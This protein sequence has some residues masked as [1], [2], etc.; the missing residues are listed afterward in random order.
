MPKLSPIGISASLIHVCY[1]MKKTCLILFCSALVLACAPDA[2]A[3]DGARFGLG[4]G[5][6]SSGLGSLDLDGIESVFGPASLYVP[7]T[8]SG[9]RLEPEFGFFRTSMDEGDFESSVTLLQIGTGIFALSP[10]GGAIIYYGG[11][12]GLIR[13]SSSF[14][15]PSGE[16]DDSSNNF[17]LGPA[18]GGEY[19]F[20]DNFSL[21]GEMQLIYTSFD[22]DE[23][24][25]SIIRTRG[26]FFIRWH[27]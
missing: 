2:R 23:G 18:T 27:F 1:A 6:S 5:L 10:V 25:F 16:G 21:G 19:Y 7:I 26:V 13:L 22:E 3:Q 14:E 17:F 20:G 11:R 4:I 8:F 15:S 12:V 9:F 24:S